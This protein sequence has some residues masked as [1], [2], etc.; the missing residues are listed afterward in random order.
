MTGRSF[1]VVLGPGASA[2]VRQVKILRI[3]MMQAK[4]IDAEIKSLSTNDY[5]VYIRNHDCGCRVPI[6]KHGAP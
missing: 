5:S 2:T 4:R 3:V 1:D 6:S